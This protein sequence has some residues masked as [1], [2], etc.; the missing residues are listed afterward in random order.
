MPS[1]EEQ[2]RAAIAEQASEWFVASDADSLG[3]QES[4]AFVAWLKTSPL[5]VEEFLRAAGIARDLR[6]AGADAEHSVDALIARA[7]ADDDTALRPFWRLLRTGREPTAARWPIAAVAMAAVGVL[8]VGL[9]WLWTLRPISRVPAA[10]GVI[11]LHFETRHGEQQTRR[12]ADNSV[13]HLNTDTAVT[14]RYSKTTRR[15]TLTSGEA[16]FEV[17]HEA[18]RPFRV[19]AGSAEITDVGTQ[20]DVRLDDTSTLVTVVEGRVSVG[21][22]A[23]ARAWASSTN[24]AP[25]T[26][27]VELQAGQQLRVV[28]NQWP[29]ATVTVDA[30]QATAWLHRQITFENEPLERVAGEF[31]R[32]APKRIEIVSPELRSLRI[33]GVF[34]ADD[35]DAFLAFLRSL[36]GVRVEVTATQILV[37]KK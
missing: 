9:F 4:A 31:N 6:E 23:A 12:L 34:A 33:S 21:H 11:T 5:H 2:I 30:H 17:A 36:D 13:L 25:S 24:A 32:Y 20:F 1:K 26:A 28:P 7:R 3:A 35:P 37:S 27:L 15:V 19:L 10:D 8:A 29:A 18:Q 22:S 16:D 14:V